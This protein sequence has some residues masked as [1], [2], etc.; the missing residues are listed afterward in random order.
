MYKGKVDVR[1][2]QFEDDHG[3]YTHNGHH[4]HTP[5]NEISP[6][7]EH[8]VLIPRGL[9]IYTHE[10]EDTLKTME[11]YTHKC[12]DTLKTMKIY[13]HTREDTLKTIATSVRTWS[14]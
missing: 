10:H 4:R 2:D 6:P 1:G 9:E 8:I 7:R 11:K 14:C 3:R 13:T 5:A 12:E